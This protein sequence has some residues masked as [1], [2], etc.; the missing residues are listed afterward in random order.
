MSNLSSSVNSSEK[1]GSAYKK[2]RRL[3]DV[4][5][6]A[7]TCGVAAQHMHCGVEMSTLDQ[8]DRNNN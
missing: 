4:V 1:G 8:Q 3:S 5:M 7:T 2:F 6:S